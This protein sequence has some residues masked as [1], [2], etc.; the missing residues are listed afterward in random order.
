MVFNIDCKYIVVCSD[1]KESFNT[2]NIHTDILM[3]TEEQRNTCVGY[4]QFEIIANKMHGRIRILN[5]MK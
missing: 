3:E 1:V 2:I 5:M 4:S